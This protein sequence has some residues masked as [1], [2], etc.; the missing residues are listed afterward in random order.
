MT[1]LDEI[2]LLLE[3]KAHAL[4]AR[5]AEDLNALIHR[6]FV[7]VNAGGRA[8]DKAGYVDT[9]CTSGKVVFTQQ[10]FADLDVRLVDGIA[11]ATLL[12]HDE[13]RID[14]RMV[15]GRYRSLCIFGHGLGRWLWIAGQTMPVG[16]A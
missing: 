10:R 13:F 14:G 4:V 3:A 7:Y 16:T 11:I 12:I 9:Y 5:R 15:T 8:F 6:D 2:R 1:A